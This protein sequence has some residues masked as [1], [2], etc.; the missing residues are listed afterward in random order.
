MKLSSEEFNAIFTFYD[1]DGSGFID[2]NELD[3]LLK[4]L[5]KK[6]KKEMS[7]QQLTNYRK[8]IMNLSNEGKLYHKEME[9]VLCSEPLM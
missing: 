2:E 9:I 6:N 7:I 3:I 4:D 1:K 8:S 5:Y